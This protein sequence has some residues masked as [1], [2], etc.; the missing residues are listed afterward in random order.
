MPIK[1]YISIIF[2]ILFLA[3][4]TAVGQGRKALFVGISD[5]PSTSGFQKIHGAEDY[6]IIGKMLERQGFEIAKLLNGDATASNI[7]AALDNMAKTSAKGSCVYIHFS[8][9]GQP[10]E[11]KPPFD[12]DDLWDESLVAID[13][14]KNYQSGIYEGE[15]HIIGDELSVYFDR[16]RKKI[17]E[18]GLLCVVIDACHSGTSSRDDI[19]DDD[20]VRGT[21][22][23]F[24]AD[25]KIFAPRIN[26]KGN[27]QID[28]IPGAGDI[29]MLEACRSYQFNKEVIKNGKHYGALS[30]YVG[31]VLERHNI[32]RSSDWV[33]DVNDLMKND[34]TLTDQNM[35]Y[36][37]SF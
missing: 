4:D 23:G 6:E 29:L 24:S 1:F 8:C 3:V 21:D 33:D 16:I 13:A 9:H 17:G 37:S 2:I 12:E 22:F 26:R 15:N 20:F 31:Q 35:V 27:F 11:D 18:D 10:F 14:Q 30:Y 7:R 34:L 25:G 36:E 28:K 32:T 19:D 5:Y